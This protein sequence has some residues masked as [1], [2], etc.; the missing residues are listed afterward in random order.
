M[1]FCVKPYRRCKMIGEIKNFMDIV[2]VLMKAGKKVDNEALE[3]LAL[4]YEINAELNIRPDLKKF[5]KPELRKLQETVKAE[6]MNK[7]EEIFELLEKL[8][9]QHGET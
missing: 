2:K 8:E 6:L 4:L 9:E 1:S 5:T 3:L 7:F